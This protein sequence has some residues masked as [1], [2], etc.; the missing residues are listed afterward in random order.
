MLVIYS[1]H[2]VKSGLKSTFITASMKTLRLKH[3]QGYNANGMKVSS[4]KCGDAFKF[5][6]GIH[7]NLHDLIR[8]TQFLTGHASCEIPINGV[9]DFMI[10]SDQHSYCFLTGITNGSSIWLSVDLKWKTSLILACNTSLENCKKLAKLTEFTFSTISSLYATFYSSNITGPPS[11][12]P[13]SF[14]EKQITALGGGSM[15]ASE[16]PILALNNRNKQVE[17]TTHSIPEHTKLISDENCEI[18]THRD[19]NDI[20][21][22]ILESL[23]NLVGADI[24]KRSDILQMEFSQLGLDSLLAISLAEQISSNLNR[25]VSFQLISEFNTISNLSRYIQSEWGNLP[26][27]IST[28]TNT[29]SSNLPNGTDFSIPNT[30]IFQLFSNNTFPLVIEPSNEHYSDVI[31]LKEIISKYSQTFQSLLLGSGAL[32]FRNFKLETA[33]DFSEFTAELGNILG[34]CL[35]YKDGISPRTH[36]LNR[37]YTSTEYPSKYDMSPHNEMSY[38]PTP[39]T[40]IVF[41]C[42]TPPESGCGGQTPLMSSRGVLE[43]IPRKLLEDWKAR[44]LKYFWNLYSR[45]KGPGKSWQDTYGTEDRAAV[46]KYLQELGFEFEWREDRLKTSRYVVCKFNFLFILR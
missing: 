17:T 18:R 21:K 33:E 4:W 23:S 20:E 44:G 26:M 10:K 25:K 46:E 2:Q 6:D 28:S 40:H 32:L 37:I 29:N 9:M 36:V 38:S 19:S 7:T 41:F 12:I 35:D 14:G 45:G 1:H 30:R 34:P 31:H 39:P 5:S 43:E 8:L 13:V 3:Y 22:V 24:M 11:S 15:P 16:A 42:L 27:H